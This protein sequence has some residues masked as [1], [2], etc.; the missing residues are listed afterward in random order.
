MQGGS[1]AGRWRQSLRDSATHEAEPDTRHRDER[2]L[3]L[4]LLA[5]LASAHAETKQLLERGVA[6]NLVREADRM[7]SNQPS[8]AASADKLSSGK[9]SPKGPSS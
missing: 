2:P 6:R 7:A 4:E 9:V 8:R 5:R 3:L 1:D